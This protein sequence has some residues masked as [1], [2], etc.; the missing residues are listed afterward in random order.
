VTITA[1]T[2]TISFLLFFLFCCNLP[3]FAKDTFADN[4]GNAGHADDISKLLTGK[5]YYA[6]SHNHKLFPVLSGLAYIM[7]LTVDSTMGRET[8]LFA[9]TVYNALNYLNGHKEELKINNIPNVR[10]FLTPGGSTHGWYTHLGW[11]HVYDADTTNR[12]HIRQEI[13][14]DFLGK[15]FS[16]FINTNT[17]IIKPSKRDSLA[18]LFYY[19]HILGDHESDKL[20]TAHTRIPI[21]DLYEQNISDDYWNRYGPEWKP[22]TN[23]ISELNKHFAI[24]FED[25][26]ETDY[27]RNLQGINRYLPENQADK[28]KWILDILFRNVPYLLRNES[29]AKSFYSTM[30]L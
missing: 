15:H 3:A 16:F 19:V 6:N 7:Y 8:E 12:W 28:A 1:C 20:T 4:S 21:K 11:D 24:L 9:P 18:A 25:Q 13:L 26:M 23:I 14:R 5:G 29:F 17:D 2:R 22:E 30:Q 27:F 10:D